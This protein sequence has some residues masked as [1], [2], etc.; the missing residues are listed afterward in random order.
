MFAKNRNYHPA[1]EDSAT[2]RLTQADIAQ[3]RALKGKMRQVDIAS[4]FGIKQPHVS[5]ILRGLA[6]K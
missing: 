3:I 4:L 1:G 6:W 5:R 2:A